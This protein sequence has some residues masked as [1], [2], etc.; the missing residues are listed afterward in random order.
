MLKFVQSA[1]FIDSAPLVLTIGWALP[2]YLIS[3]APLAEPFNV[4][5][6]KT[7]ASPEPERSRSTLSA[8]R[9]KHLMSVL[10]EPP[11]LKCFVS[12]FHS[13]SQAPETCAVTMREFTSIVIL[14]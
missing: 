1:F 14:Q 7:S 3:A 5:L 11:T 2:L 6:A 4:E 10:P 13:R 8:L 12:P 9:S